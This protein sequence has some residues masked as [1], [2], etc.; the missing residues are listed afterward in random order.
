MIEVKELERELE[1]TRTLYQAVKSIS[2]TEV[3]RFSKKTRRAYQ[4][5]LSRLEQR[6]KHLRAQL[7]E[8]GKENSP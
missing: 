6:G 4:D 7:Q 3:R 5:S 8:L 1:Q 2:V